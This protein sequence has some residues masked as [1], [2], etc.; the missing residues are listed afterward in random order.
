MNL[1][2]SKCLVEFGLGGS[3]SG[4]VVMVVLDISS[5]PFVDDFDIRVDRMIGLNTGCC[6]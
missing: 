5:L 3:S 6:Y 2:D 4:A 1:A